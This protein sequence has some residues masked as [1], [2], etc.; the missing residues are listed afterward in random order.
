MDSLRATSVSEVNTDLLTEE[1]EFKL[2]D[3]FA[4]VYWLGSLSLDT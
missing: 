3:V 2:L 1:A 4:V